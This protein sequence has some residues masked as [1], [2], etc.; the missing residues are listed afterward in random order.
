MLLKSKN[1]LLFFTLIT[2]LLGCNNSTKEADNEGEDENDETVL[3]EFKSKLDSLGLV[4]LTKTSDFSVLL[5]QAWDDELDANEPPVEMSNGMD[6]LMR[7][8]CFFKDGSM[9]QDHRGDFKI[10]QWVLD[11]SK[12]PIT[13]SINF[14]NGEKKLLKVGALSAKK[15]VLVDDSKGEKKIESFV[16][17]GFS[18]SDPQ[19]DPFAIQNNLWRIKPT[20]SES[21]AEIKARIKACVRFYTLFYDNQI[22]TQSKTINFTGFP[23]CFK[24]YAGGIYIMKKEL[25]TAKW[26]NCFYNEKQM[27]QGYA[28]AEDLVTQKYT[29]PKDKSSWLVKNLSVLEQML[30]RL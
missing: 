22:A 20:K 29:W 19:N 5:C 24:W 6:V 26:R 1:F 21:E 14:K 17:N 18:Y 25:L 12:K 16:A 28:I 11:D 13:I 15:M 8:Y 7:G 30:E 3:P 2:F 4:D 10:G 23:T 9:V 27:L